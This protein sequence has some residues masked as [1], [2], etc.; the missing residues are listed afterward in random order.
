MT[1]IKLEVVSTLPSDGCGE[2]RKVSHTRSP[3]FF[4]C[5][6][7]VFYFLVYK[8]WKPNR[9]LIGFQIGSDPIARRGC[10]FSYIYDLSASTKNTSNRV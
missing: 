3:A 10:G 1:N 6:L 7:F 9:S 5:F 8:I 4:F 2:R